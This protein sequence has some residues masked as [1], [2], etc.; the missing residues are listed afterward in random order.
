MKKTYQRLLAIA[1]AVMLLLSLVPLV[2]AED[3][4]DVHAPYLCG[5]PDG[6]I[7]PDEPLTREALAQALYRMM[8]AA[9]LDELGPC[10]G[11]FSD[12]APDR[13]S[14]PAVSTL[15]RLTLLP[16]DADG[17]FYPERGVTGQ[18]L[19]LTLARI[20]GM[21]AGVDALGDLTDGWKAQMVTFAAGYG[22]VMG[23]QDGVFTPDAPLTR[24][25]FAQIMNRVLGRTP[26]SL[27]DLMIG[28]PL[29]S[30]NTD[31][32]AWYFLELQEA[33]TDHSFRMADGHEIW[34]GLG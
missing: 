2:R 9:Y 23:L 32:T 27:D 6:T 8:D 25:Q 10:D 3:A 33:A 4:A 5:Y 29:F 28:M 30:D 16:A 34:T 20:A 7:R 11:H 18:E 1:L 26:A 13:W 22:W 31:T 14:Y 21:Q 12:V 19:A 17:S 15:A 24:A